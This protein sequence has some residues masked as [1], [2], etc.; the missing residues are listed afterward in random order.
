[1][2]ATL[3][4][5][6]ALPLL[7]VA[8]SEGADKTILAETAEPPMQARALV[9]GGAR[10]KAPGDEPETN[11]APAVVA[12]M[13]AYAHRY[14]LELPAEKARSLLSAHQSAC[15]AAGPALCQ[16]VAS[17]STAEG[18]DQA[19]GQLEIRAQPV[20]LKR[21]RDRLASDTAGAGGKVLMSS[22]ETEDLTR[23]MVDTEAALRAQTALQGRLERLLAE[24]PGT[25]A[26][27]LA[28][29]QELARVRGTI[30]ATRSALE[31]M[32]GRV[33]TSKLTIEY[34]SRGVAAPDGVASPLAMA[35]D[36]FLGNVLLVIAGLVTLFSFLL[37]LL[38]VA[39]PVVW[40][41]MRRS[42]RAKAARAARPPPMDL[43]A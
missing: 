21:F 31:V 16:V 2:R 34:V 27:A 3:A 35:F 19:H 11:E 41:L 8:C 18:R 12:P 28:I 4:A 22:L 38:L 13:L 29:E 9:D 7:L 17:N 10:A 15:E 23:S 37:P 24:R 32:R 40:W 5:C 33:A 43:G 42:R 36:A 14:Q 25:L 39:A 6:A 30:D 1:M 20:W 26:D